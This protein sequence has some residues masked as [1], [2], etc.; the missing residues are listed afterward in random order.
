MMI[1]KEAPIWLPQLIPQSVKNLP[2][3]SPHLPMLSPKFSPHIPIIS[4]KFLPHDYD[5]GAYHQAR[6]RPS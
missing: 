4:P 2:T 1:E 6:E 5:D 3:P